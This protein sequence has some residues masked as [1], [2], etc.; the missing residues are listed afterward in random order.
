METGHF[1]KTGA[2][3]HAATGHAQFDP[4]RGMDAEGTP[5]TSGLD[6]PVDPE[7]HA[8]A[9]GSGTAPG[10]GSA[11]LAT[12]IEGLRRHLSNG[13][14]ASLDLEARC[15]RRI[16]DRALLIDPGALGE[17]A[18]LRIVH[19]ELRVENGRWADESV[20]EQID[21]AI[22]D[23]LIAD[24]EAEATGQIERA[25]RDSPHAFLTLWFT[26]ESALAR[27]AAVRFNGLP[28]RIRQVFFGVIIESKRPEDLAASR[29]IGSGT[30]QADLNEA[31]RAL[32]MLPG[33]TR[34]AR[35]SGSTGR[36][37]TR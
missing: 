10:G 21:G 14:G 13:G 28:E 24:E 16:R 19:A 3:E 23:L 25:P 37:D 29:S 22:R 4:A 27:S 36:E 8:G 2:Y 11:D 18:L 30:I 5:S 32:F 17:F 26:I 7:P 31:F 33:P 15:A 1:P 9:T 35:P 34:A 20:G 12:A 6:S